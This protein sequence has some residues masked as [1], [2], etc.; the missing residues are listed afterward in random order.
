MQKLKL[1]KGL[2][3]T[4]LRKQAGSEEYE[5]PKEF[6]DE[7]PSWIKVTPERFNEIKRILDSE[8]SKKS[9]TVGISGEFVTMTNIKNLFNR[10][11]YL[12]PD[13]KNIDKETDKMYKLITDTDL[14]DLNNAIDKKSLQILEKNFLTM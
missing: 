7:I 1:L 9:K 5:E 12:D 2:I 3:K 11:K 4:L 6:R 8:I 14:N 10:I 13:T